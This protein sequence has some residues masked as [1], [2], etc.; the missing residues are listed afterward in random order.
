[1]NGNF[2]GSDVSL[3]PGTII[4][5]RGRLTEVHES[6][7]VCLKERLGHKPFPMNEEL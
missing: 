3:L 5:R 1:M 6:T 7:L 2:S 4:L